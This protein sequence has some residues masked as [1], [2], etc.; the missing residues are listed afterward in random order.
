[1]SYNPS[2]AGSSMVDSKVLAQW[3]STTLLMYSR[4]STVVYD[5]RIHM[6]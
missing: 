4:S 6:C 5:L 3:M 2:K 1:M